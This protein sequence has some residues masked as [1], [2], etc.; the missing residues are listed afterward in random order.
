[1]EAQ[2]REELKQTISTEIESLN[3]EIERLAEQVK[4]IAPDRAI[5]RLTR[6]EAIQSKS[7]TQ[8]NLTKARGR[9][10]QLETALRKVLEDPDFG[11]CV[12]CEEPIP[13]KR[14]LLMPESI[15]CVPCASPRYR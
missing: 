11:I 10:R 3:V 15:R 9:L 5:G 8:A 1:M 13:I 14:L 4:P 7:I 6:M 2:Y 12:G